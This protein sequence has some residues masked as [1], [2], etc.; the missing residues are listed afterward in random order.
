MPKETTL[1]TKKQQKLE[2]VYRAM[3]ERRHPAYHDMQGHWAFLRATYRGGREWFNENI[4]KYVKEGQ[5]EFEERK[6]RAY[7]FNHTR[8]VVDLVQKY[9]FK[10]PVKRDVEGADPVVNKFWERSTRTGL[11]IDD[12]MRLASTD[13]AITGRIAIVVDNYTPFADAQN[14]SIADAEKAGAGTFA[15]IVDTPDILDYAWGDDGGLLWITLQEFLRDDANP[16]TASGDSIRRVR[17]WTRESWFLFEE[18]AAEGANISSTGAANNKIVEKID[19]GKH[20][21]GFVPVKLFD[22]VATERKYNVP[23][24]IDDIAYL[25][26][27]IANYL[28]NLDA[29]I[30]DQT[31]SQLAIPAQSLTGDQKDA[32]KHMITVGT[33]RIFTYDGGLGS[34]AK[35]EFLSP[36]PKQAG[37][38]MDVISKIINE[39]YSTIGLAG[40][41]TKQD[42]SVGID[43]SS[44]V[45][46]A[47]DFERVNSLLFAKGQRCEHV[48]NWLVD[49]VLAW[50]SKTPPV[51]PLVTYPSSFDVASLGD[52][53]VTSEALSKVSAPIEI[54][55]EQMKKVA[56]KLFP[57][58]TIERW[59]AIERAIEKWE[60]AQPPAQP[61]QTAT[62]STKKPVAAPNRQGSVT[63]DTPASKDVKAS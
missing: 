27:A 49:T 29:I 58:V 6:R 39:I 53:L 23:S 4:F 48:E 14:V 25:D 32:K 33:N 54:R 11:K 46:K 22:N 44:G 51:E 50:N 61:P 35:P 38:I 16:V 59:N 43:N 56:E 2:D 45:A 9:L 10:A 34:T 3:F 13:S 31:F 42:N 5:D 21:L 57:Q 18:R 15:Y 1:A 7:R 8:E 20:G 52:E 55:R 37:V 24:L 41:R 63:P 47:Y 17:L 28:S 60:D 26:R 40:E 62:S 36:D 12:L 30:Q 19:E